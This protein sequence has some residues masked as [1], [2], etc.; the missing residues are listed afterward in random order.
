M[1]AFGIALGPA[2]L[3]TLPFVSQKSGK[4]HF[5]YI[6]GIGTF[7]CL[8]IYVILNLMSECGIDIYK[9]TSVLGKFK[10]QK[11]EEENLKFLFQS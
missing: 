1:V 6:Y 4:I 5:G 11:M 2:V 7:G 3:F 9:T 10:K 8:G